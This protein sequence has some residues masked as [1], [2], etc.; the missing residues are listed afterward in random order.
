MRWVDF[1]SA[2]KGN[3]NCG[4]MRRLESGSS[5]K[6]SKSSIAILLIIVLQA[7]LFFSILPTAF[8]W[9]FWKYKT[10]GTVVSIGV[11]AD[12]DYTVAGTDVGNIYLFD[13]N[14]SVLWTHNFAVAVRC[15]AISGDGN[16]I[17][18]GINEY[19]NGSPDIYL[20]DNLGGIIWQKDLV[21]G[22]WPYDVAI[23][24]DATYIVTGDTADLFYFY[25]I[26]GSQIW[27][28][29][30]GDWVTAVSVSS[31]GEYAAAGSWDNRVYFFNK[32][33]SPLWNQ[34]LEY[35]VDAVSISP[36]GEYVAAGSPTVKDLFLFGKNGSLLLTTPFYLSIAAVS[37]SANADRIAVGTYQKV[38]VID[39][40]ANM[41]FEMKTDDY[42]EDVAITADGKFVVFGCGDYAYFLEALP[43]STL[44]CEISSSEI[45]FGELVTVSG[46]INP[47]PAAGTQVTL[48][49]TRPNGSTSI[50]TTTTDQL[51]TYTNTFAPDMVGTWLLKASWMGD[52]QYAGAENTSQPFTVGR[53]NITCTVV[54]A[55]I[56]LGRSATVNGA[57]SP[58]MS[59]LQIALEYRLVRQ[60]SI[61]NPDGF[62]N[63]TKIVTTSADGSFTDLFTPTE[64]GSWTINASWTGDAEHMASEKQTDL[65]V[66]P[67]VATDLSSAT[68]I[69]LYWGREQWYCPDHYFMDTETPTSSES[70]TVEFDPDDYW[71]I[72][73]GHW[74]F[75]GAHTGPLA[76]SILIEQGLWNLSIWAA[77]REPNQHFLVQLSYW[78]ESHDANLIGS[79][80]TEYFNS[81]SPDIPTEFIHSF[82]VPDKFIPEGNCLGFIVYKC[83]DADIKWFFDS[84]L[85]ASHLAIPP[86]TEVNSRT[87]SILPTTCGNTNPTSGNYIYLQGTETT[88]TAT[89]QTGYNFDH[90]ELDEINIGSANPVGVLMDENH[91]IQA[92][93]VDDI[94]PQ[95]SS[96]TQDPSTDIQPTQNV[97]VTAT[98]TDLGSGIYN[99]TLNYSTD[100]G[101]T[102]ISLNMSKI[103]PNTYQAW[104][105]EYENAT[106]VRYKITSYDNAG[107][108]AVDDNEGTYYTYQVIPEYHTA[109]SMFLLAFYLAAVIIVTKRAR[110][111]SC[112]RHC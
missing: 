40:T 9:V 16:R 57:I 65:A 50:R 12:G 42:V 15:V 74:E 51:G 4:A 76:R 59:G 75:S 103:G 5:M 90:W 48:I 94:R 28:Y 104:I 17:A 43:P 85:H 86:S 53:T 35:N 37:V 105:P 106:Y 83:R 84:T 1:I 22:S 80:T 31:N 68:P 62:V 27:T 96:P 79:W 73:H 70:E 81:T 2:N 100:N 107:N 61:Y 63:V 44:T 38:T 8:G 21:Q 20:F 71:W 69:A 102:W 78:N 97:T 91:I 29:T 32:S 87:L 112:M 58:P 47:S 13:G 99:A 101:T 109:I 26:S 110:A 10:D 56:F 19:R 77:A 46:Y 41:I 89:P 45:A 30:I 25:D 93:F 18:V 60:D 67:F 34:T 108:S 95:I 39:K 88:I 6:C 54:P 55:V 23:S 72:G 66:N 36:E 11:S 33:G 82:D 52:E 111:H 98:I 64:E 92:V 14:G 7:F 3:I 49:Y 24:P